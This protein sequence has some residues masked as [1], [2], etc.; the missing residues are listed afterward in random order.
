MSGGW[1]FP[2]FG[3]TWM[4]LS[5]HSPFYC[6]VC[7]AAA[8][9]TLGHPLQPVGRGHGVGAELFGL[10]LLLAVIDG[11][12]RAQLAG[13]GAI[14]EVAG[15]GGPHLEQHPQIELAQ[16]LAVEPAV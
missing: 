12:V 11:Q 7:R 4:N 16:E 2:T 15:I 8:R 14:H 3:L 1:L 6:S 5:L 13:G 9:Q 10:A